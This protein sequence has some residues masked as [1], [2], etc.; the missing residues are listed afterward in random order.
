MIKIDLGKDAAEKLKTRKKE[1]KGATADQKASIVTKSEITGLLILL[2]VIAFSF[3]PYL[4]VGQFKERAVQG[5]NVKKSELQ[6]TKSSLEQEI[7]K[8]QSYKSELENF[9]K[10]SALINQRLTSVNE[11]LQTRGGPVN[12][13]DALGQSLPPGVW[14]SQVELN[15]LPEPTLVFSGSAFTNEEVTDFSEKLSASIYL[16]KIDLKDLI[17][18][19]NEKG[20]D[21]K[22]FSFSATPKGFGGKQNQSRE[23]AGAQ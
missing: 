9:E 22:T 10:Q 1:S 2:G 4:F 20:E 23:T 16:E 12:V 14:L 6:E 17:G 11:L 3:L 15:A 8:Y 13:L 19:K 5:F 18:S 21:I 7:Q